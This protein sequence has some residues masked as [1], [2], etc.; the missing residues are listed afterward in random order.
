M[1]LEL[2]HACALVAAAVVVVAVRRERMVQGVAIAELVASL[3]LVL[4]YAD[5]LRLP[6]SDAPLFLAVGGLAGWLLVLFYSRERLV[7]VPVA[8]AVWVS[9]VRV[10]IEA[11][12]VRI[13]LIRNL[14][15]F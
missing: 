14:L 2:L 5:L 3:L 12:F 15:K 6:W 7:V 1:S 8:I 11:G 13:D 4:L 9:A 10:L